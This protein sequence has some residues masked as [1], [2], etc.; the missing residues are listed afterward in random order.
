MTAESGLILVKVKSRNTLVFL[1]DL[2]Y[3][4]E[5]Y[6]EFP[7]LL[8]ELSH[9]PEELTQSDRVHFLRYSENGI[10]RLRGS[11]TSLAQAEQKERDAGR[12]DRAKLVR[13]YC[14]RIEAEIREGCRLII[15]ALD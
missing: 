10:G 14:R 9:R 11:L 13:E 3:Q 1:L 2:V 6:D 8:E 7:E 12:A 4:A 5:R 15:C